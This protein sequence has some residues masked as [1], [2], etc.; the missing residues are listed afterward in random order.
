M[1]DKVTNTT[2]EG[3]DE[4]KV[5]EED[6]IENP[7]RDNVINGKKVGNSNET[8]YSENGKLCI[9]DMGKVKELIRRNVLEIEES[10]A[11][12][13]TCHEL[14]KNVA[15]EANKKAMDDSVQAALDNINRICKVILTQAK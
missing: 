10:V 12:A 11:V 4:G 5:N 7:S 15:G 14:S 6:L 13:S 1:K 8:I 9:S 3:I 2:Q